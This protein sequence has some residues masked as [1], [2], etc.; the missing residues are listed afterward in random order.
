MPY[1]YTPD[2]QVNRAKESGG[3]TIDYVYTFSAQH[4]L[5]SG[6]KQVKK[7]KGGPVIRPSPNSKYPPFG[8]D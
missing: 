6:E 1:T 2:G 3:K 5:I 8:A 7:R 4:Q